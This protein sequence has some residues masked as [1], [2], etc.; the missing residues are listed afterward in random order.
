MDLSTK[1]NKGD[2]VKIMDPPTEPPGC[3]VIIP[4]PAFSRS[5]ILLKAQAAF[6]S[7]SEQKI[8]SDA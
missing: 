8:G 4:S 5:P 6:V 1:T 2:G 3:N 7:G